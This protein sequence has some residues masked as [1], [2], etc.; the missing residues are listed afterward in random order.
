MHWIVITAKVVLADKFYAEALF[1][2]S[3]FS[4][5]CDSVELS[6][7]S[8]SQMPCNINIFTLYITQ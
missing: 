1:R 6:R 5:R 2:G 8:T 7:K 4:S 3:L